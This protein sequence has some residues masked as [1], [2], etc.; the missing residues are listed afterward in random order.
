MKHVITLSEQGSKNLNRIIKAGATPLQKKRVEEARGTYTKH[1]RDFEVKSIIEGRV[2][3]FNALVI[4][5][6][7]K[8]LHAKRAN[9]KVK[10]EVV[11]K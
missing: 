11:D 6:S 10:I 3:E 8:F 2:N 4:E 5:L 1:M 7:R 9:K